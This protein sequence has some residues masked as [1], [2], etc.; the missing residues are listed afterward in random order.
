MVYV[1][2]HDQYHHKEDVGILMHGP[3]MTSYH[4][5]Y[6]GKCKDGECMRTYLYACCHGEDMSNCVS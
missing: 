3:I 6:G 2:N 5:K 4:I 1:A